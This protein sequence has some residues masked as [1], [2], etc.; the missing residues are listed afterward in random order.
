MISGYAFFLL[1]HTVRET[2]A[3]Q[4]RSCRRLTS[5]R[6]DEKKINSMP[7][8]EEL[9][10]LDKVLDG[11]IEWGELDDW[12]DAAS[13][14]EWRD[15]VPVGALNKPPPKKFEKTAQGR[16]VAKKDTQSADNGFTNRKIAK[17]AT[18]LKK[19]NSDWRN[20]ASRNPFPQDAPEDDYIIDFDPPGARV[21]D[22]NWNNP[23]A[24]G[25]G[26]DSM[27]DSGGVQDM[28][29]LGYA[30]FE[31]AFAELEMGGLN[32]RAGGSKRSKIIEEHDGLM[33]GSVIKG[34]VWGNLIQPDGQP[35]RF[36]R[37]HKDLADIVVLYASPRRGSDEFRTIINEYS[38]LPLAKLK[39]SA[40][41][42]STD[43]SNDHR[44]MLKRMGG[45]P[46]YAVLSDATGILMEALRCKQ[47]GRS[48]SALL[49]LALNKSQPV[50]PWKE[51]DR[52]RVAKDL[53][54]T[55][56][57][58]LYQGSWDPYITKD[59]VVEEVEEYRKNPKA[60]MQRQVGIS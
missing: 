23:G 34:G 42:V 2:T 53:D 31:R 27:H 17:R 36:S 46:Q 41:A 28:E 40:V 22:R 58:V 10:A 54:A 38:K 19:P 25:N 3:F 14:K 1:F 60:Y 21:D 20:S 29:D 37:I 18:P 13:S 30:D 8:P 44:K 7:S 12:A 55:I 11:E 51:G 9:V 43:D 15:D 56:I 48:M 52:K 45:A 33:A 26:V 5:L 16:G 57:R 59:L 50:D 6:L 39:I 47:P 32:P 4:F 49:I 35:T 24:G